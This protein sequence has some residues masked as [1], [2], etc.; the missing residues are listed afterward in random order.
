[1][2]AVV[3]EGVAGAFTLSKRKL[4]LKQQRASTTF[5]FGRHRIQSRQMLIKD[6]KDEDFVRWWARWCE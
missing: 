6:A 5:G 4:K 1:M 3:I 2:V